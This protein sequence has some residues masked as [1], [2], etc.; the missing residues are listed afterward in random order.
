MKVVV[1]SRLGSETI[2]MQK[3]A[4][5]VKGIKTTLFITLAEKCLFLELV[6]LSRQN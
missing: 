5:D 4:N 1:V 3:Q 6:V 2:T